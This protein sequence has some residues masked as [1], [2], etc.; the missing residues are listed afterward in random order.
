[1][2]TLI[3]FWRVDWAERWPDEVPG[4][5]RSWREGRQMGARRILRLWHCGMEPYIHKWR[6]FRFSNVERRPSEYWSRARR[7][8]GTWN[9]L[10]LLKELVGRRLRRLSWR[11]MYKTWSFLRV[12]S[13][14]SRLG[15]ESMTSYTTWQDFYA[16]HKSSYRPTSKTASPIMQGIET[17]AVL[18]W[19]K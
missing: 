19:Q 8:R 11:C 17:G 18:S 13:C 1:M 2:M 16:S 9:V 12:A 3:G 6:M 5:P 10:P 4:F 15:P 7:S 14:S